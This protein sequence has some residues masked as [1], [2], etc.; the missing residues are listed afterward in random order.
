MEKVE[1]DPEAV[2]FAKRTLALR[3]ECLRD[4]E[5]QRR[6]CG[7]IE[8]Y[9]TRGGVGAVGAEEALPGWGP[10]PPPG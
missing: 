2:I 10:A 4:P 7:I 9:V 6:I 3:R 5:Q 1:V 8:A